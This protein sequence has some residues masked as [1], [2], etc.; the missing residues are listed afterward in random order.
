MKR[1]ASSH[2]SAH[3]RQVSSHLGQLVRTR[4]LARK[5]TLAE[6]AERA[7][8]STATLK[9]VEKGAPS[10]SLGVWLAVFEQLGLLPLLEQLR[11]PVATALLDE[12][13][14]QRARSSAVDDLDF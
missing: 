2:I 12:T 6:L 4:R 3:A 14:A 9:R 7:A 8:V 13:R 10:V 1:N 5:W 11:D